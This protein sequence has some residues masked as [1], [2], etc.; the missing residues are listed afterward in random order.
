MLL[1]V[2]TKMTNGLCCLYNKMRRSPK[3]G[4]F[5]CVG[6]YVSR[7][8]MLKQETVAGTAFRERTAEQE[9]F[10]YMNAACQA[11]ILFGSKMRF[12]LAY[13]CSLTIITANSRITVVM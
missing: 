9:N 3:R 10:F 1:L 13:I 2:V 5:R 6:M 11:M 7:R 4:V 12:V 8:K